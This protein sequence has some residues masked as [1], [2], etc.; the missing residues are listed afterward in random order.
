[1]TIEAGLV[2]GA[3]AN[4]KDLGKAGA[5][6]I[7]I[8]KGVGTATT[9]VTAGYAIY[10]FADNPT[11]GNA[12]RAIVQGISAGAAFVPGFGWGIA[13]GINLADAIWGDKF[14]H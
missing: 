2:E 9:I 7:K 3:L 6:A 14:Y 4:A 8:V 5:K 10:Q 11:A 1:V 13:L 12:A